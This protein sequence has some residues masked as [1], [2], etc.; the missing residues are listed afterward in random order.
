MRS[1]SPASVLG[2]CLIAAALGGCGGAAPL[3]FDLAAVPGQARQGAVAR[4]IVVSEPTGLQPFESDRII[5]REPGG[6]LSFLGGGQWAD[7]LPRLIQTRLV[8]SLENSGRL[9]SVSRPGDKV[10]SDYQLISE[11]RAFDIAAGSGEAVVDLSAKLI[12]DGSGK[13]VAARVFTARVPVAKVDPG[14]AAAGLDAALANVLADMV[15]WVNAG[16]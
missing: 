14:T 6:A 15:R 16:R 12:A 8:Q 13:V 9:R 5:V 2:A 10:A 4:A 11:I 1:R 3:T 7:R